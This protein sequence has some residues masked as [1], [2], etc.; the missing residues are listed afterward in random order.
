MIVANRLGLRRFEF[1]KNTLHLIDRLQD[2]RHSVAGHRHAVAKLAHQGFC[3]VGQRFQTRQAEKTARPLDRMDEPEDVT[4]NFL[5]VRILLKT[6]QFIV[7]GVEA[8]TSLRQK[9]I[10]KIIHLRLT[11]LLNAR[12]NRSIVKGIRQHYG[13]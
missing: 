5:V 9:L 2:Q 6:D 3:G 11:F 1:C 7:D 8:F 10:E 4:E 12:V 13:S